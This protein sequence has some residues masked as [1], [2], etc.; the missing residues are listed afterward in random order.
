MQL[1]LYTDANQRH[2]GRFTTVNQLTNFDPLLVAVKTC[3][4][5]ASFEERRRFLEEAYI[6]GEFD[7]PHIIKLLGVCSDEPIWLI[8]EYAAFGER[9]HPR[10]F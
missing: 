3:K 6:L 5:D 7:H 2:T 10:L 9:I 8:M 4:L 1:D